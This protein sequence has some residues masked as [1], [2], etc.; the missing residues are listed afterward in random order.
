MDGAAVRLGRL[1]NRES[2]RSFITAYD[3][4]ITI[5]VQPGGEDAR[6]G[7]AKVIAGEPDGVLIAPGLYRVLADEFAFKGAPSVIIRADWILNNEVVPRLP[8]KLKKIEHGENYRVICSPADAAAMGADAIVMFLVVGSRDGS[9]FGDNI[10]AL[11]RAAQEAHA[12]GLPLIVESVLWGAGITDKTDP[13]LLAFAARVA[14]ELGA[15]V[16]KTTYTGDPATMRRVVDGSPVPV[17]V[18][19]GAKAPTLAP[20]LEATRGALESGAK[21]VVYGRNVWQAEDPVAVSR[22]LRAIIHG[23]SPAGA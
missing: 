14:T 1:F 18:L 5:G 21:G 17:L 11:A 7:L 15:D 16:I 3:H 12:V 2:G 9:V 13:E 8:E 22:Q 4:G 20:V 23:A 19:G 10:E 6:G